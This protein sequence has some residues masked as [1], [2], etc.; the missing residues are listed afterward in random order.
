MIH[1]A[2]QRSSTTGMSSHKLVQGLADWMVHHYDVVTP[3][4]GC[5]MR[6]MCGG[7]KQVLTIIVHLQLPEA[8]HTQDLGA[9]LAYT[10]SQ[11]RA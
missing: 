8:I 11:A 7:M 10:L 5:V 9:Y 3:A 4:P 1:D 2:D 6:P